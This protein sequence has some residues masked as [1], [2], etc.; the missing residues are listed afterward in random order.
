MAK[1]LKKPKPRKCKICPEKFIPCNSL[2]TTCSP[3]CAIQL[4]TQQSERRKLQRE[5]AERAA[6]NKRKADVKPLSAPSS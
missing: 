6:W 5:K 1:G 4:A 3:K 2:H